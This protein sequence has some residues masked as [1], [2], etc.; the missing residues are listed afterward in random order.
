MSTSSL[1][2]LLL[3]S[4]SALPLGSFAFSSG[5]E[6]YL[7][8]HKPAHPGASQ[9]K[10]FEHFL[11]LSVAN[12]ASTAL[13]YVQSAYAEP[14]CLD[15]L[16]NDFDA[17]T[18]CTVARRASVTQGRALIAVWERALASAAPGTTSAAAAAATT[19]LT[20][21]IRALKT[22]KAA[23]GSPPHPTAHLPPLFGVVARALGLSAHDT[24]YLFLL[25]HVKALLSAAV[26]ASV[27][28]PYQAQGVL[29]SVA[30]QEMIGDCL[31][32]EQG[33]KV[34]DAAVTVPP[35]DLWAGRHEML[36][37]RIFNS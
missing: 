35:M 33:R 26:R 5:L 1:H 16:D 21:F 23:A 17:S 27:M 24:A 12:L 15:S 34:E 25:S 19:A 20:S 10:N 6:S 13:P 7:A 37:S 30:L 36:Y 31:E 32:R 29:A 3:L 11:Q 9:L 28:G 8:H 2:S 14:A 18:S 22:A 4:D